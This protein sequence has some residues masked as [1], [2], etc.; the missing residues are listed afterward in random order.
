MGVLSKAGSFGLFRREEAP[1]SFGDFEEPA[2]SIPVI[3]SHVTIL[4]L[5]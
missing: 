1:L 5:I 2:L 3:L 4:Q